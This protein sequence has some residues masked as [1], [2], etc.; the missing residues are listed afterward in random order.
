MIGNSVALTAV[1]K[2]KD[3]ASNVF[4][5]VGQSSNKLIGG[6]AKLGIAGAAALSGIAIG[7]VKM[8]AD[9]EK[10]M[11]NVATLVD[12]SKESMTDMGSEVMEIAKRVPVSLED[13]TSALYDVRSAGISAGDAMM[14]LERS[15]MLSKTGLGTTAEAVNLA[16]SA[17]NSFGFEG[18]EA[19]KVFDLIQLTVKA[20]K[21]T[22]SELAQ[23][24]GMVSGV[25][26][27]AGVSFKELMAATAALTTSGLKSSV[28]QSQLRAAILSIQAPTKDMAELIS[29]LG[30]ESGS[31]MIQQI[32]LV[33][34][35]RLIDKA[36]EGNVEMLKKS[37]GS[38]EALGSA[39]ALTGAQGEAFNGI[40]K[41]MSAGGNVLDEEFAKVKNTFDSAWQLLK[42]NFNV[43]MIK[44][45]SQILPKLIDRLPDIVKVMEATFN[46]LQ[47][48]MDVALW[49]IDAA[50]KISNI[51]KQSEE[52]KARSAYKEEII[53]GKRMMVLKDVYRDDFVPA[54]SVGD[55]MRQGGA[56]EEVINRTTPNQTVVNLDLRGSTVTD[57]QI[58]NRLSDLILKKVN[59][60]QIAK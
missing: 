27:T 55:Y 31:A 58:T 25:A 37:Y 13:L 50:E 36:A 1:I 49:L 60:S 4:N 30:Y 48:L 33:E 20:G 39:L 22:I 19:V 59:Y 18:E 8:A 2:A 5:S 38:V 51:T 14:V 10:S 16:T 29:L 23:S 47:K 46:G 11:T 3:E 26:N 35:M 54:G 34:S 57:E 7:S 9:F 41:D 52:A 56:T 42:N 12:T 43:E 17:I 15:A 53:D 40:M 24:F 44:L 6:L 21:T 28:A 32:G 45:G